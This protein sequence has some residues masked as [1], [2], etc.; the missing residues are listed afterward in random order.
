MIPVWFLSIIRYL[1]YLG[2]P[3]G[4]HSSDNHPYVSLKLHGEDLMRSWL[5]ER[6]EQSDEGE[7]AGWALSSSSETCSTVYTYQGPEI[8]NMNSYYVFGF[9]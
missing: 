5:P 6:F 3:K 4:D 7:I 9:P 8:P 2:D 1:V